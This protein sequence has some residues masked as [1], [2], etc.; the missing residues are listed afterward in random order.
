[1]PLFVRVTDW[2]Q[3]ETNIIIKIPSYGSTLQN[4][5]LLIHDNYLKAHYGQHFLEL[6]LWNDIDPIDS[7]CSVTNNHIIF[8]LKKKTIGEWQ[9]L[10]AELEKEDKRK[11]RQLVIEETQKKHQEGQENKINRHAELKRIAVREQIAIDSKRHEWIKEVKKTEKEAALRE[12]CLLEE[13]PP[14]S[15]I[16]KLKQNKN[17]VKNI[18]KMCK[19]VELE[20]LNSESAVI[21]LPRK[22]QTISIK[23]TAREFPTPQ[24]ESMAQEEAEWLS[25]QAAARRSSETGEGSNAELRAEERNPQWLLAKGDK[26]LRTGDHLGAINAYSEGLRQ[27]P[28]CWE[29]M[30]GRARAHAAAGNWGRSAED[31]SS[32]LELLTPPLPANR[33]PRAECVARRGI[34]LCNLGHVHHGLQELDASLKLLQNDEP[35]K[36]IVLATKENFSQNSTE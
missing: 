3:T 12:L 21:P 4:V 28:S 36:T 11:L 26:F 10:E 29:L 6:F 19:V 33:A 24:R 18:N 32:A 16:R 23:F 2:Q 5:D 30:C 8:E 20:K 22:R 13:K 1:M 9:I 34:A 14:K 31:C 25:R 17:D 35:L 7:S 15:D 27:S